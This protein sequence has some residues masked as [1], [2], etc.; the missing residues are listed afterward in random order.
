MLD[1]LLHDVRYGVRSLRR[2][3]GFSVVVILTLM[4]S[5]GASTALIS[6]LNASVC[7]VFARFWAG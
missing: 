7:S 3:P 6:L 5:I 2:S 1:A 4:L